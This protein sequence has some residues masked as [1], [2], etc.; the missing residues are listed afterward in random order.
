MRFTGGFRITSRRRQMSEPPGGLPMELTAALVLVALAPTIAAAGFPAGRILDLSHPYDESTIFWPTEPGF[1]LEKEFDGVAEGGYY[2]RSN[3]FS[4][5]EHG[6][7]HIDAPSHFAKEGKSV[8]E[9]PLQQLVGAAVVVDVSAKCEADR[10]YR[11]D[12][13]DL[14]DWE[15]RHGRIPGGAIVL[16]RT[17]FAKR[18]PDRQAY[19][20][21]AERGGEAVRKLHFP[22]LHPDGAAWLVKKRR[23]KAVGIDT[24]SIDYGQSKDFGSHVTLFAANVP[25]IENLADLDELPATGSTVVAL[26]MKIRGGSGGPLRVLAVVP[27]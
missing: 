26:P 24:A 10:D 7:T 27:H 3:K 20:G 5:P 19:L 12:V 6:G 1:V 16:F 25:A 23:P 17:G 21:T 2:Y 9:I 4:S 8:D 18:W 13:A 14:L 15:K 22:G 11:I